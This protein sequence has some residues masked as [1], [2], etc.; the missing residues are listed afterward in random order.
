MALVVEAS[1]YDKKGRFVPGLG[2]VDFSLREDGELQT[3][4]LASNRRCP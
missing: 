3:L 4:S 1:V 2:P